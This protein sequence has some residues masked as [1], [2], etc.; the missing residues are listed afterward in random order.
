MHNL[1]LWA[2]DWNTISSLL[3]YFMSGIFYTKATCS[4]QS[5][6]IHEFYL[7]RS[8]VFPSLSITAFVHTL[9]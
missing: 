4:S 1:L 9:L 2:N 6:P 7:M 5:T 3:E 8:F